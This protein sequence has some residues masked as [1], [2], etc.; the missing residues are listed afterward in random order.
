M[1]EV[2]YM[3]GMT[4]KELERQAIESAMI[5]FS[6]NKTKVAA[7]LGVSLRTIDNKINLYKRQDEAKNR[8]S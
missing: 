7:S 3:V 2:K 4:L 5:F 8:R 6:G 1:G